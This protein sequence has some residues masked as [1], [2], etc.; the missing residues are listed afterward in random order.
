[1]SVNRNMNAD[2][3]AELREELRLNV[4]QAATPAPFIV[5]PVSDLAALLDIAERAAAEPESTATMGNTVDVSGPP[6]GSSEL[7][8]PAEPEAKDDDD[9]TRAERAGMARDA[10]GELKRPR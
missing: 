3:I 1:M 8:W 2:R 10:H 5:L 6:V 9:M 7:R 4:E